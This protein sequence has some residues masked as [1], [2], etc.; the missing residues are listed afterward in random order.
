MSVPGVELVGEQH[1][2][3]AHTS[4]P[5]RRQATSPGG[6]SGLGRKGGRSRRKERHDMRV[7]AAGKPRTEG[8]D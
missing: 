3:K 1:H 2:G 5:I 8:I 4:E 7:G 6:R